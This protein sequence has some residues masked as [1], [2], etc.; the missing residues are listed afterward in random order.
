MAEQKNKPIARIGIIGC[1][2][3]AS[4]Y[5]EKAPSSEAPKTHAKAYSLAKDKFQLSALCDPDQ[6]KLFAA[7]KKWG[8]AKTYNEI[9]SFLKEPLDIVSICTPVSEQFSVLE[10]IAKTNIKFLILEKPL[11]RDLE[12][13]QKIEK[14]LRNNSIIAIVNYIRR[15]DEG[16]QKLQQFIHS[17]EWGKIQN[18][19]CSYGKG[20]KNNGSHMIHLLQYF[21][22][23]CQK[24]EYLGTV[25]DDRVSSQDP[26]LHCLF[27]FQK[28]PKAPVI[29]LAQDHREYSNFEMNIFLEKG[30]VNV[31]DFGNAIHYYKATPDPHYPTYKHLELSHKNEYFLKN[32]FINATNEIHDL[33]QGKGKISSPVEDAVNVQKIIQQIFE[34]KAKK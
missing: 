8:F 25:N 17:E 13:A 14:L 30:R 31:V 19:S 3:I 1:G 34:S 20:L 16:I 5:D 15:Y 10:K 26:T 6:E 22:G 18:I 4:I 11:G 28:H 21:L 9:D 12:E 32:V 29:M 27:T 33:W 23:D 7:Q 2:Q 24:A